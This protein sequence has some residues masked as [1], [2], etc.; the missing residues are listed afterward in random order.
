MKKIIPVLIMTMAG[1]VRAQPEITPTKFLDSPEPQR[2]CQ[3]YLRDLFG[4]ITT[5][6]K[7]L[8]GALVRVE[9]DAGVDRCVYIFCDEPTHV[10]LLYALTDDGQ[11]RL[12]YSAKMYGLQVYDPVWVFQ[13]H[14]EGDSVLFPI[15]RRDSVE[16]FDRPVDVTVSSRGRHYYYSE[17]YIYVLDQAAHRIVKLE[18]NVDTDSLYWIDAFGAEE[19]KMPTAI[20]YADHGDTDP[21]NDDLYVTDPGQ[22]GIL[23]FSTAGELEATFGGWGRGLAS[24]SNPTGVAVS[25]QEGLTDRFY[26]TDSHNHRV[27]RYRSNGTGPIVVE[28]QYIF[29]LDPWPLIASVAS[30][31]AGYVYVVN[32]FTNNITVLDADLNNV[33]LSYGSQGYEPGQ[34][35]YPT[36]IYID[37]TEMHVCESWG[38]S[39]GIQ[40]FKISTGEGKRAFGALPYQFQLFQNYPN[41]FNAQ[42]VIAFELPSDGAVNL[43]L[44]NILGQRVRTLLNKNLP[45]GRH[46]VV[47]NGKN[48]SGNSVASGVYFMVLTQAENVKIRK[49][50]LLK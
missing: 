41:P 14:D 39:S 19:L 4:E 44:Y 40:S 16:C 47:W 5:F 12:P 7:P 27:V 8:A 33:V 32:S 50:L 18:Y 34:F 30:D 2:F 6:T 21:N 31:E 24:V 25:V 10:L 9:I 13:D 46:R 42:T 49:M 28:R 15:A 23:R 1:M 48:Q 43:S 37:G 3:N 22:P 36:D 45:A 17:D 38:E 29:P 35:D 11:Q 26:V 20:D